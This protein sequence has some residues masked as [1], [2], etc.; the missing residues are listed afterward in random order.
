M[1]R[2]VLHA[3]VF[4]DRGWWVAQCLEHNLTASSKN[5]LDLRAKLENVL[6]V[7]M[8]ADREAGKAPFSTLPPAPRRFW[9]LFQSAELWDLEDSLPSRAPVWTELAIA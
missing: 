3:V 7:Q 9:T 4:E 5:P 2:R 6:K 1:F 8:E